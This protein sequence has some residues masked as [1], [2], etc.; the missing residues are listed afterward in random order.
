MAKVYLNVFW[1]PRHVYR[2]VMLEKVYVEPLTAEIA[3]FSCLDVVKGLLLSSN[4]RLIE[5][6]VWDGCVIHQ[7][8]W[9]AVA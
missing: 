8:L 4:P 2:G 6:E 7:W 1:Q 5:I 3:D 9:R